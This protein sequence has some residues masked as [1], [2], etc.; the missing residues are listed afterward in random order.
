[1]IST[2]TLRGNVYSVIKLL[3]HG[4]G[5]YSYLVEHNGI[6]YVLK[7]IHHNPCDYYTFGN[8]I[9]SEKKDYEKLQETGIRIPQMLD[10][11]YEQEIILKEYIEGPTIYELVKNNCMIDNYI[12]QMHAM[13]KQVY[14]HGL[15]IDYFPANL[16]VQNH[17]LYYIDYECNPYSDEWNFENWG[18][19]YWSQTPEFNEHL[20]NS[21]FKE[22]SSIPQV[23]SI[24]LGGSRATK[25]NDEKSD[26][27]V[28]IYITGSIEEQTR[29]KILENYCKYM[30]IG[31]CFW[32][33]EDDVTLKNGI[34]MDIIYRDMSDFEKT[35]SSVV[36]GCMSY[37]GYTTCMWH[38]LIT[39]QIIYDKNQNLQKLQD[40]YRIPYPKQLKENIISKNLKLLSGMLPS[41]DGQIQKAE[42]RGDFVSVNHR[43]TEF[44]ASYFDIIFALNEMTH[45][46]E[47][48]MQ[49]ICSTE[50]SILPA[51]FD[52][53]LNQLFSTMFHQNISPIIH[54]MV[55]ELKKIL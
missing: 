4:K 32:E 31:N 10:I 11:D 53:N 5:G 37:N 54:A 21:L 52:T 47:K 48:R 3:G 20:V 30:E 25:K 27:D 7:Q 19:K 13:A 41:F 43:V 12:I 51:N 40:K 55:D 49:S 50:C 15:N 42:Q 26:Y 38:N 44:L 39:S 9:E 35:I 2:F 46:G 23:E 36:D 14:D 24:S 18:I 29:R 22:L 28:Y 1:M 6:Q 45:P 33:L 34:D 17:L 16:V 8:K